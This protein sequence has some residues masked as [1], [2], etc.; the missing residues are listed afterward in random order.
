MGKYFQTGDE[1]V[2][3][4][5]PLSLKPRTMDHPETEV[6]EPGEENFIHFNRITPIYPLTEGLPQRWLRGLIWRA[7]EKFEAHIAEPDQGRGSGVGGRGKDSRS[8]L[9]PRPPTLDPFPSRANAIHMLH[10]PE[11][12]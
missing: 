3:Y 8:P 7:L 9:D 2:G 11:A 1:V 4:G 6:V 12:F 5:K 10:F